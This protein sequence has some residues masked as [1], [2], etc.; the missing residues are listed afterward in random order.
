MSDSPYLLSYLP[1]FPRS[2]TIDIHLSRLHLFNFRR[3]KDKYIQD[4]S[5]KNAVQ[6][7]CDMYVD[8][9][10]EP[11]EQVTIAT[12]DGNYSFIPVKDSELEDL[13]KY[14]MGL[15]FSSV[16]ENQNNAAWASEN[17]ILYHQPFG[18]N[19]NWIT[20]VSGSYVRLNHTLEI[21]EK[22]FIIPSYI[23]N[24]LMYRYDEKLLQAFAN[25]IDAHRPENDYLFKALEWVRLATSNVE[26][27]G[28]AARL[29]MLCTAFEVFFQLPEYDKER[30]FAERLED[31]LDIS[32]FG[33][34]KPAP[35]SRNKKN[36]KQIS[37]RPNTMYGWW[38]RDFYWIRSEIVH[39]GGLPAS[40]F[41]NHNG[42][43]HFTIAM[44]M[45]QFCF[46][47]ALERNGY[48]VYGSSPDAS[49]NL[50]GVT[51]TSS[52]FDRAFKISDLR[53]VEDMIK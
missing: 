37:A 8:E 32:S 14:V 21:S 18:E 24:S 49:Y 15:M 11:L 10:G 46:Y 7:L 39:K 33:D 22:R 45:L 47:K 35:L 51:V 27:L 3:Y 40:E 23:P 16:V 44:K 17:F 20:Y 29:V 41:S 1:Y 13:R 38:A 2:R 25:M 12:L 52:D 53:E 48:L 31:L 34:A 30:L 6:T 19:P 28:A 43:P 5:L 36:G 26:G 9:Q 50:G 4:S 42:V